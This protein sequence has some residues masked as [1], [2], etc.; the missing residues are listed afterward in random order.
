MVKHRIWWRYGH[1]RNK[2]M[3]FIWSPGQRHILWHLQKKVPYGGTNMVGP[4]QMLGITCSILVTM[5]C[6]TVL[7]QKGCHRRYESSLIIYRCKIES[8]KYDLT[9]ST[10]TSFKFCAI[11]SSFL[12]Y[13]YLKTLFYPLL[14]APF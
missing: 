10:V 3:H 5:T 7:W 11:L 14:H 1:Y 13:L 8:C 2:N 6:R 9:A 4:D 12:A